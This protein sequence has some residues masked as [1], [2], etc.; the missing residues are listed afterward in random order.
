MISPNVEILSL[1]EC[2]REQGD[3]SVRVGMEEWGADI[4]HAPPPIYKEK[5]SR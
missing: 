2:D 5:Y 3:H 1:G 4:G